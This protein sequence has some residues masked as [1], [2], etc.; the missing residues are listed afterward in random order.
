MICAMLG[1]AQRTDSHPMDTIS[2]FKVFILFSPK[3]S[4]VFGWAFRRE[5]Q[6]HN[7]AYALGMPNL[8]TVKDRGK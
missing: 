1:M 6:A 2:F 4:V 5:R 3:I 8:N 7:H